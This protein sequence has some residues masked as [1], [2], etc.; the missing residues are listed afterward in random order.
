[1]AAPRKKIW[2]KMAQHRYVYL[3][4]LPVMLYY[5]IFH[6]FPMVGVLIA[7]KDYSIRYTF[8]E[9]IFP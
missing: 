7:F 2:I 3:M 6:Y 5:L 8:W 4:L 1:M 9:N